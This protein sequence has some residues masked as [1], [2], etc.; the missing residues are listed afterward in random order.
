[1]VII[2]G[3]YIYVTVSAADEYFLETKQTLNKD[4]ASELINDVPIFLNDS[5]N[6][7]AVQEIMMHH[8]K[9]NPT[10]EVYIID[11]NGKILTYDAPPEKI[12]KTHVSM[13]PVKELIRAKGKSYVLGNDP[14]NPDA[15]KVFSVAP[16][17]DKN[18]IKGY[19]YVILA[20]E[21][22]DSISSMLMGNFIY[23]V[24]LK[25]FVITVLFAVLIGLIA[26]RYL[27]RNLKVIE[28]G[29][30][31]FSKGRYDKRIELTSQGEFSHLA[32]CL[33]DMAGTISRNIDQ[34][35]AIEKLRKELVANVSHDLRTPIAVVRGYI[36]TMLMKN[37]DMSSEDREKYLNVVLGSTKNLENL[38][39]DLFEL[40]KLESE[41]VE[42]NRERVNLMELL[43][44]L[45][46]RYK[47][48]AEQK[49]LELELVGNDMGVVEVDIPLMERAIQNLI[50][51]SMKFTPKGGK[52]TVEVSRKDDLLQLFVRDT[53]VGIAK[54]YLP[55]VFDRYKKLDSDKSQNA[56]AGLG[57]AIVKRIMELHELKIEVSSIKNEGTEFSFN[58]PLA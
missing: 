18:Y 57:L 14:R 35:K 7:G 24:G 51:N 34:L 20:S 12:K 15:C 2:G 55:F 39:A 19:V 26:I 25:T 6:E 40:S 17:K 8:M 37:V 41:K 32:L 47:I 54:E 53:G 28:E 23:K 36:E 9:V 10:V 33:N 44:D 22:Y 5:L 21:E 42:L 13:V 16:I 45:S 46:L 27:T 30:A 3:V 29:V 52:V 50:E 56:G 1:M 58:V 11:P 48:I 4:V 31:N 49:E 38:I 43:N